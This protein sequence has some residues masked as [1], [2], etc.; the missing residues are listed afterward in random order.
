[1][2]MHVRVD[3][4]KTFYD[5]QVVKYQTKIQGMDEDGLLKE[6][7]RLALVLKKNPDLDPYTF[8]CYSQYDTFAEYID[9]V[10]MYERCMKIFDEHCGAVDVY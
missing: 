8:D 6:A 4:S 2:G 9:K 1:M 5:K 3:T 10:G 7:L